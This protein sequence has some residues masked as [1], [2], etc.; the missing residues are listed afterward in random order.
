MIKDLNSSS[1][2]VGERRLI[3]VV[4]A[5][6]HPIVRQGVI[7]ELNRH[8]DF[9]ILGEAEDGDEALE[10]SLLLRPDVLLLDINMSGMRAVEVV[11]A[12]REQGSPTQIFI[13]SAYGD[14]EYVVAMLKAGAKGFM[15]KDEDPPKIVE[16]VRAVAKGETWLSSTAAASLVE[17]S[18]RLLVVREVGLTLREQEVLD[19]MAKGYSNS[20]IVSEL[21]I[22][23]GTVKNHISRIYSKLGVH[24]RAEAVA[25]AWENGMVT[26]L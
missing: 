3:G 26:T 11:R 9:R 8:S 10:L 25:W 23:E 4:V 21:F 14:S 16:G 1:S 22:A 19:L 15:V 17:H 6:D 7:G 20:R 2:E 12:L 13:L 5:D 24:S 18:M